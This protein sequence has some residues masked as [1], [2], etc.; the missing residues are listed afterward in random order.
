MNES[1]SLAMEGSK[2]KA[3]RCLNKRPSEQSFSQYE[4][5]LFIHGM[6]AT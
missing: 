6:K 3:G 4:L 1:T 5:R 2:A